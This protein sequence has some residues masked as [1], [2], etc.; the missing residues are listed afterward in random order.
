MQFIRNLKIRWKLLA[1]VLPLVIIPIVIVGFIVGSVAKQQAYLG[2]TETSKADLAHMAEFTLDLLEAHYQQFQVY[3]EDKRQVIDRDLATLV[4]FAHNFVAAQHEQYQAGRLSL[5]D[6]QQAARRAL[7]NVS[8]GETGYIYALTSKGELAVHIAQEGE[9]VID[10]RDNDGR[11]FIR[12]IIER[13]L[14][15]PPG[16][17]QYSI[18]PWRNELLGD[19]RPRNKVVAFRYFEPW[20]WIIAAGTYLEETY[21]DIAFEQQALAELKANILSKKVGETGYI[22]AMTRTG[23]LTIHPFQEGENIYDAQDDDGRYFIREMTERKSGWIRYPWKNETDPA[24]RMKIVHYKY[25]EPWDWI[26]AV[27]SYEDEFYRQANKIEGQI[28]VS[29]GFLTFIVGLGSVPLVF[30]ASTL[31]TR[32]IGRI[33]TGIREVR[34]GRLNAK[35]PVNSNDELGELAGDFNHMTEVLQQNKE[36]ETHLA[37]QNKMASLGVLSSG[38]AHEINNPLGVILGYA[39]YL[40]G[41]IDPDDPN[42]QF[43]QEI[44]RES[45]RCK[46]I[47]QDLL[48][49][50]RVPKPSLADTDVN[51]LLDHIMDFAANHTD[52]NH[53]TID[54]QFANNLPDIPIDSDQIRQ[55]AINL[56]LNA[57]AAMDDGGRL[58]VGTGRSDDGYAVLTFA[59]NGAGIAPENLQKIFEPFFT[60]K[61]RGTGLGLAITRTIIEQHGGSIHIDSTPG[62]GTT[63]TVKLP[64]VHE[65]N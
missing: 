20:D 36:L 41:K 14:A 35:L 52:L 2:I 29:V 45:K 3:Q 42:F 38:V 33:I 47:V 57:G 58:V 54:K 1:V 6:A 50:A 61:S 19:T 16:T 56:I 11:Y 7:K 10:V 15:A 32:P 8:V 46:N 43:I 5:L 34:R 23:E 31:L 24:P 60:T 37:Q 63:V 21:E 4:E 18:Y 13:A 49:Y 28:L 48:S 51:A 53:V 39:G 59:D 17:V 22:Y 27:G 65:V 25:F 62:E 64:L 9:T 44:K 55:V 30:W 40:E 12:E 26:V